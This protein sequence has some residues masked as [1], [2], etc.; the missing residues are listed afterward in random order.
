[1]NT[2]ELGD[3]L[4]THDFEFKQLLRA[5]RKGIISESTFEAELAEIERSAARQNGSRQSGFEA[6]GRTYRSEQAAIVS[7]IDKARVGEKNGAEAFAAW[8]EV[9]KTDCIRLGLRMIAERESYHSRLFERR[10]AELGAEQRAT[11]SEGGRKF[12]ERLGDPTV[13]DA[14][15]LLFFTREVG[16]PEEIVKPICELAALVKEDLA[17]KE[18][19]RLFAEDELS[20][21]KWIW[22]S[23]AALNANATATS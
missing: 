23:C 2:A 9:C 8:A 14:Q 1:V 12:R 22:E 3:I 20:T 19:L 15:K 16:S 7:F 10:L 13:P 5:L 11:V 21:A 18:A 4:M 17:T 6:F